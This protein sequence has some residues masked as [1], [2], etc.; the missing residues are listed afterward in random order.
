[1]LLVL[2]TLYLMAGQV[3]MPGALEQA[4]LK[5]LDSDSVDFVRLLLEQGVDMQKFVTTTTLEK[6]YNSVRTSIC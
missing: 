1:M 4:M 5:A 3:W 2:N 6:L